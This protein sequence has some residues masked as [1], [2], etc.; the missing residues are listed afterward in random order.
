M[1]IGAVT[2]RMAEISQ[3]FAAF[4]PVPVAA[5]AFDTSSTSTGPLGTSSDGG[6][7]SALADA[8]R[9]ALRT[10]GLASGVDGHAVAGETGDAVVAGARDYLGVPYVW[11]GTN[12]T[13]GLDCSGLTQKVY[14]EL[15][16]AL[17]RVSSE[18][19]RTG[20][21]V[22]NLAAARPGD[23]LFFDNSRS[24]AGIDHVAIY[25][26]GNRM[27]E[28]PRP[29]LAVR[30]TTVPG[31]PVAIRRVI[32]QALSS[33]V[34]SAGGTRGQTAGTAES[35]AA[36]FRSAEQVNGLPTGL[37]AAVAKVESSLKPTSWA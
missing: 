27:V 6:F 2:A 12:P 28:A 35:Y 15:G 13:T 25:T 22:P 4:T 3:R 14:A 23:L 21:A 10:S 9:S 17:P 37:L 32:P 33:A 19:A 1:S 24:R 34:R 8:Q 7:A 29:G 16:I 30:E 31:T 11:G 36:M 26:G 18:Q 20:S 5:T